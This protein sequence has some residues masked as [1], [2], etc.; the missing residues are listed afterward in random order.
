MSMKC[1]V[2]IG[3]SNTYPHANLNKD[4]ACPSAALL[5]SWPSLPANGKHYFT[6]VAASNRTSYIKAGQ[7]ILYKNAC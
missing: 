5:S 3:A 1:S 6:N 4:S 2:P 7:Q